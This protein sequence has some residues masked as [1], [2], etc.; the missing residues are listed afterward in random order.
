[1]PNVPDPLVMVHAPPVAGAVTDPVRLI[2]ALLA[3]TEFTEA[4]LTVAAGVMVITLLAE[5]GVQFPLPALVVAVIVTV[6]FVI[7]V[8]DGV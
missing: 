8:A 7:S 4:M 6:P 3:Q 1:L 2:V 5:T